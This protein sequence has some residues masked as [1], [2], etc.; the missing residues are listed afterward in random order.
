M[1]VYI[2]K[3]DEMPGMREAL[4]KLA[5]ISE[6]EAYRFVDDFAGFHKEYDAYKVI[7]PEGTLILK[8]TDDSRQAETEQ[9]IYRMCQGLCV[10][11]FYGSSDGYML[12]EYI[13]GIDLKSPS[14]AGIRAAGISLAEIMNAFPP[15]RDYDRSDSERDLAYK[16]KQTEYLCQEPLL[17]RAYGLLLERLQYSSYFGKLRSCADQLHLYREKGLSHRL[18]IRRVLSVLV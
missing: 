7:H 1:G 6:F 4:Q 8:K 13:D 18:G 2:R 3:T 9:K 16:M 17:L 15:G 14:N 10:P 11:H 5:G 12:T